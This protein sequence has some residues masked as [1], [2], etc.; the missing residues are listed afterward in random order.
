M[1]DPRNPLTHVYELA[2]SRVLGAGLP[3]SSLGATVDHSPER[4]AL[5]LRQVDV[6]ASSIHPRYRA[7]VLLAAFTSLRWGELTA[8]RRC[9]LDLE[10][11]TVRVSRSLTELPGGGYAFGPPKSAAGNRKVAVPRV[12][13]NDLVR[14]LAYFCAAG[15]DALI[16]TSPGDQPLRGGNFRRRIWLAACKRAGLS[17]V[18]FHD[19]RHTGN[20]LAAA[21]GAN[22]RELMDRMG[23][24]S[25]RAALIYLHGSEE[26][27][28]AIADAMSRR[29][30]A[31][32]RKTGS[33]PTRAD[34][35][36][37]DVAR[38]ADSGS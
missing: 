29:A 21:E 18:H 32:R 28:Q 16:F 9:D 38:N 10:L 31:A 23:H 35:S 1:D 24:S 17:G 2:Q 13:K 26:R 15:P 11:C 7:L 4:A 37:T 6:L 3:R 36:G 5:S 27:Q 30:R 25:T 8:L 19:L 12:I 20:D 34:P 22:L 33:G 14:H